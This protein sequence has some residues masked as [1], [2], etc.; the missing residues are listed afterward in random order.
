MIKSLKESINNHL[1]TIITEELNSINDDISN[2]ITKQDIEAIANEYGVS[3]EQ[4]EGIAN[5]TLGKVKEKVNSDIIINSV[6]TKINE[7]NYTNSLSIYT[8][9][10]E[11][12]TITGTVNYSVTGESFNI[13]LSRAINTL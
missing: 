12:E 6:L 10:N 1:S 8:N 4:A 7:N 5:A 9:L 3:Y 13:S 11:G 2:S